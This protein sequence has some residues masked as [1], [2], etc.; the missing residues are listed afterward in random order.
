MKRRE[1]L[2]TAGLAGTIAAV[3][4]CT[5]SSEEATTSVSKEIKGEMEYRINPNTGDKVSL[6]GYGCMRW[7]ALEGDENEI[8]QEMV[9]NLIDCA[10]EHGVNYFDTAPG[11][12]KGKSEAATGTALSRHPRDSYFIATKMSNFDEASR[13]LEGS[14]K[15]FATSLERLK[16]DYIDY[17]LLHS[18]RGEDDFKRRFIDNGVIDWLLEE[19]KNGRIRNLGFSFHGNEAGFDYLMS[20][21]E[22]YHWDFVQIMYNYVDYRHGKIRGGERNANCE[23]LIGKL[24]EKG[25]MAVAMEPLLGGNLSKLPDGIVAKLK[26]RRPSESAASW[27]FRFAGTTPQMLT[28]LSGMTYMEHLQ[29]NL[30]TYCGFEPLSEEEE[31][32]LDGIAGKIVQ[33]PTVPCNYC[34]YCMPCPYGLDI[35]GIFSHY[36]NCVNEDA[37]PDNAGDPE[38]K[39]LRRRFL[40]GYSRKI[41]YERQASHCIG[42]GKCMEECPQKINIPGTMQRIDKYVEKLK[43]EKL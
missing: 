39:K 11:Y 19:R 6:L 5:G 8:D 17:L 1:F 37:M 28:V 12:W 13:T 33:F 35:P 18:L 30:K 23:Y 26:E 15:M 43:Q 42:C 41:P 36:N 25:I 14:K 38:F 4:A 7:P 32:F 34:N 24:A 2:K 10:L 31:A 3:N 40:V 27:A 22:K 9:N 16:T 29:D 20:L 21:H